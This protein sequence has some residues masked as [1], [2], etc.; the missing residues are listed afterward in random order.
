MDT[1]QTRSIYSAEKDLDKELRDVQRSLR[2]ARLEFEA[3]SFYFDPGARQTV[4]RVFDGLA[5]AAVGVRLYLRAEVTGSDER[6]EKRA[7]AIQTV[8]EQLETAKVTLDQQFRVLAG[9]D[10]EGTEN[11]LGE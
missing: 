6:A 3:R 10:S 2:A 7:K 9:G 1:Y 8:S 11:A 4:E 5:K